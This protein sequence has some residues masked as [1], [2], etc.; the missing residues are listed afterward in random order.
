MIDGITDC[1]Y[2][3]PSACNECIHCVEIRPDVPRQELT[4]R[5]LTDRANT[6]Q[7]RIDASCRYFHRKD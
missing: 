1:G 6:H 4:H 5:E 2:E 7:V 3:E